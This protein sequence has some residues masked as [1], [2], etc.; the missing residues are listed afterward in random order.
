MRHHLAQINIGR[1]LAPIDD[2][3]MAGF[4]NRLDIINALADE[5][6][7]FVWRLQTEAGNA[8]DIRPYDDPMT[9]VNMSVWETP[10]HLREFAYRSAHAGVMRQRAA[11]FEKFDGPYQALWWVP[12]GHIPTVEEAKQRLEHLRAHGDTAYAFSFTN[13]F[14]PPDSPEAGPQAEIPE[15]R[16]A[17]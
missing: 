2:P 13:L 14:P 9:L 11:W 6:P 7:G 8:T 3:L 1:I 17:A 12:V 15:S 10:E 5:S 4:V 16:P